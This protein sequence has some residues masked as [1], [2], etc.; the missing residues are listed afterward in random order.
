MIDTTMLERTIE[1]ADKQVLLNE[2]SYLVGISSTF[3]RE[4]GEAFD[5]AKN[6]PAAFLRAY[7]ASAH[8]VLA[9]QLLDAL[10][11]EIARRKEST[12]D[13]HHR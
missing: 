3:N 9:G 7:L 11:A 13:H 12:N 6:E 10:S 2:L 1:A 5:A 4:A 8:A